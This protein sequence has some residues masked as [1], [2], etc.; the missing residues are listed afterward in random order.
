MAL[1]DVHA[2]LDMLETK[3]IETYELALANGVDSIVTIGTEPSDHPIVLDIAKALYPKV[4]CTLG[5]HPHQATLWSSDVKKFI[6]KN[7]SHPYV[8]AVG[9]IGL[10]YY[11][12]TCTP[13]EQKRAYQEQLELSI[14]LDLPVQIHSRDAENDTIAILRQYKGK[15][16]G[17][18]H[19]FTGTQKLADACLDLGFYISISGVVTF[20][21]AEPLRSVV[22]ALPID[23]ITVETDSPFL[24]P[25][26]HRGKKNTPAF[27]SDVAKYVANLKG[28][29]YPLFIEKTRANTKRIFRKIH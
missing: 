12:N 5:I 10:D 19:C 18:I 16:K 2:H 27:V 24:A 21:N 9:E 8:V 17:I 1:I 6:M 22:R 20:K 25:A 11:Y 15:A 28:I 29:E 23:R 14:E 13:E 3:P 7:S 26:P 4:Y